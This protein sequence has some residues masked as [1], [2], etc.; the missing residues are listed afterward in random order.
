MKKQNRLQRAIDE[1]AILGGLL[2]VVGAFYDVLIYGVFR[3]AR[4][5]YPD[6]AEKTE[7][8]ASAEAS[9]GSLRSAVSRKLYKSPLS[10]VSKALKLRLLSTS[11]QSY[12]MV[13]LM[14]GLFTSV[15]YALPLLSIVGVPAFDS[16]SFGTSLVVSVLSLVFLFFTSPLHKAVTGSRFLSFILFDLFG[17]ARPSVEREDRGIPLFR[18]L[19]YGI[20]LGVAGVFL[21]SPATLLILLVA[22]LFILIIATP[23][24]AV[25]LSLFFI[26]LAGL[27]PHGSL[28]LAAVILAGGIGY[29]AKLLLGKRELSIEPLDLVMA[30]GVLLYLFG[31]IFSFGGT[32]SLKSGLLSAALL[33]SYFLVSNLMANERM[34]LR[35]ARMLSLTVTVTAA[36]GLLEYFLGEAGLS[37]GEWLDK[38]VFTGIE[39]RISASFGNPNILSVYLIIGIPVIVSLFPLIKHAAGRL[40]AF[41]ALSTAVAAL[42]LTWSRGAWVGIFI[43]FIVYALLYSKRSP[44]LLIVFG[45]VVPLLLYV[46]PYTVLERAVSALTAYLPNGVLDSSASYRIYTWQGVLGLLREFFVGGI[47]VGSAAF[48]AVYPQFAVA[49]AE[50]AVHS[51]SLYLQVFL[52]TGISGLLFLLATA[53]LAFLNV[54]SHRAVIRRSSARILHVGAFA[55]LVAVFVAGLGDYVLYS[56]PVFCLFFMMC[57][58]TT[59]LGRRGRAV[60]RENAA[61]PHDGAY[62]AELDI[63]IK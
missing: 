40:L 1:S 45:A 42:V 26:P 53:L 3:R 56:S 63:S 30:L 21:T 60:E 58:L 52:E 6:A 15:Y 16:A 37:A 27:T 22:V 33:S 50:E 62:R 34:L 13:L 24:F 54:I 44:V 38:T 20:L 43:A 2:R 39:G 5:I 25:Y 10:A 32:A 4:K 36:F 12:G 41:V 61:R 51:H 7:S 8:M 18:A 31:G 47:G 46:L 11:C 9:E 23:E 17:I 14:F 59:A 57:G 19:V 55:S 48:S 28:Y 29:I 35:F 49:G